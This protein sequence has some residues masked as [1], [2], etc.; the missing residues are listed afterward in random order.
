MKLRT[1]KKLAPNYSGVQQV[2]DNNSQITLNLTQ[3]LKDVKQIKK[4][5]NN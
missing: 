3:L 1:F 2:V 4:T 5:L